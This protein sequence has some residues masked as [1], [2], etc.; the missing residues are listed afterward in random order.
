MA[1]IKKNSP[2]T[3]TRQNN[4]SSST[5]RSNASGQTNRTNQ[6]NRNNQNRENS[7]AEEN[8][9][10][11]DGFRASDETRE[12]RRNE[13]TRRA[14]DREQ[15]RDPSKKVEEGSDEAKGL[16]DK[17]SD[18]E[19]Q[20]AELRNQ[21]Q[22]PQQQPQSAGGC[23][24][25]G[26]DKG[27]GDKDKSANPMSAMNPAANQQ[28]SGPDGELQNLASQALQA[29]GAFGQ[30]GQQPG[31]PGMPSAGQPGKPGQPGVNPLGG[32]QGARN[33]FQAGFQAGAGGASNPQAA[34]SKSVLQQ[35]ATQYAQQGFQPQPTTR[36]LVQ[37][38]LGYDPFAQ[39]GG[40]NGMAAG[41]NPLANGA[42]QGFGT[43][44]I[45]VA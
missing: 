18:L 43:P 9:R 22:Q 3:Q 41:F 25:G 13:R 24:G 26:G 19:K 37:S 44:N 14:G 5:N 20:L 6:A 2:A 1:T 40:Q 33:P 32:V 17:V 4:R 7:R 39:A 8:G 34:Q 28:A 15:D 31:M 11:R 29:S 27:G 35:K 38:V 10:T 45:R 23:C 42:P 30:P 16:K 36:V 12:A 21:N